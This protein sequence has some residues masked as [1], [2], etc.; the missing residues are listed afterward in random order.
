MP[1]PPQPPIP[2]GPLTRM[3]EPWARTVAPNHLKD[4]YSTGS[5]PPGLESEDS[6]T[7][8][9]WGRERGC[10]AQH[11]PCPQPGAPKHCKPKA[12]DIL[13]GAE[14]LQTLLRVACFSLRHAPTWGS[15]A[16]WLWP[17]WPKDA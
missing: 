17:S 15:G 1:A 11:S 3:E 16:A 2:C 8:E 14:G 6:R 10:Q 4:L 9:P 5:A 12:Q 13:G 7:R